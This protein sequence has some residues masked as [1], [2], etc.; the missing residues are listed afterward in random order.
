MN[1]S[2]VGYAMESPAR[3]TSKPAA[4]TALCP[5]TFCVGGVTGHFQFWS[6]TPPR[7]QES[8]GTFS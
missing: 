2:S 1:S 6:W 5:G 7:M 4:A 3:G 8:D